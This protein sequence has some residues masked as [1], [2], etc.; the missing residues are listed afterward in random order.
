MPIPILD[1]KPTEKAFNLQ[2]YDLNHLRWQAVR[3]PIQTPAG[4]QVGEYTRAIGVAKDDKPLFIPGGNAD[5]RGRFIFAHTVE[6]LRYLAD[7]LRGPQE[8]YRENPMK[9]AFTQVVEDSWSNR[10]KKSIFGPGG[11]RI[12]GGI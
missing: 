11:K 8:F 6:E 10:L 7:Q 1:V 9:E 5:K 2:E 3:V 4:E 12:R